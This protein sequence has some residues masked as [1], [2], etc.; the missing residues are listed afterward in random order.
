MPSAAPNPEMTDVV[1]V[2][3]G[4]SGL[5]AGRHLQR[6]NISCQIL[7][8]TG[9]VDGKTRTVKSRETGP[10]FNDVG[11]AWIND[12]SQ[13][14]MYK[15]FQRYGLGAEIQRSTGNTLHEERDGSFVSL[16][17]GEL[18]IS[19]EEAASLGALLSNLD[20]MIAE[21][22]LERPEKSPGAQQLDQITFKDF[23]IQAGPSPINGHF[24]DNISRG[25]L[26]VDA[27]EISTLYMINYF[28]SG[29]GIANLS[30][31]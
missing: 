19:Q 18:P 29:T 31:D 3:A 1:I 25:L 2:G 15:L 21:S 11:A 27:S 20:K 17:Y 10:G 5:E 12:T 7:E 16:P 4:L 13:S 23:C 6:A 14:E 9:Q 24:A 28:K 30:S 22:C 26:G 8:A